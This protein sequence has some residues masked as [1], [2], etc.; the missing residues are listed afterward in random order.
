VNEKVT[1]L[2]SF[3]PLGYEHSAYR[4]ETNRSIIWIDCPSLFDSTMKS[5]DLIM[6]THNHFLGASN[7]YQEFLSAQV[8]IHKLDSSHSICRGFTFN[9]MFE[10]DFAEGDVEAFH[11][12]GHT[13]G[14]TFYMFQDIVFVCDYVFLREGTMRFN[15]FG[16]ARETTEGAYKIREI[17]EARELSKVCGHNYVADYSEWKDKPMFFGSQYAAGK[18][19]RMGHATGLPKINET[20]HLGGQS[21]MHARFY[22]KRSLLKSVDSLV[23]HKY[24]GQV[25]RAWCILTIS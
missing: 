1:R 5:T 21:N 4:I 11:I 23:K 19:G 18:G 8:W 14:F 3:P 20:G 6:F 24:G 9:N 13:P 7:L 16:P 15:P 22:A 17:I 2:N 12:N 25:S 10:E